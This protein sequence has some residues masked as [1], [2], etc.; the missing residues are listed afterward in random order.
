MSVKASAPA[1]TILFGEH[2][3]VFGELAVAM[4]IDLRAHVS[5]ESRRD[6]RIYIES[7][8]LGVSGYFI[9]QNF[10]LKE[11]DK[12]KDQR[13]E[14]IRVA[15]KRVQDHS[16]KEWGVDIKIDS[17]IPVAAGLGSSAAILAATTAAVNELFEVGLS[18]KEI[19]QITCEAENIVHGTSSGIDPAIS[20]YGGV[21][22]FSKRTGFSFLSIEKTIP[23]V[24]GDTKMKRST[25]EMV[26]KVTRDRDDYSMI[27]DPIIEIGG[28]IAVFAVEALEKGDLTSLGRLMNINHGLLS[29]VGVSNMALERLVYAARRAGAFGSKLTGAGGGGCMIAL[30]SPENLRRVSEAIEYEGGVSIKAEK[31]NEGV[32]I[33]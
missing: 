7:E 18:S 21:L 10:L 11:G 26:S 25:G 6:K 20:T 5:A 32:R 4:A 3:V 33:E 15:V 16:K 8:T 9:K 14:P 29:S 1:K 30:T 23:L 19:F 22:L 2:F 28:N 27:F 24:I 17:K 31:S 12:E 13:L